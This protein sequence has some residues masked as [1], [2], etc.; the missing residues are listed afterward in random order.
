MSVA[1]PTSFFSPL[2]SA[3]FPVSSLRRFFRSLNF[4]QQWI[5]T[6]AFGMKNVSWNVQRYELNMKI[7]QELFFLM[8]LI[9]NW[10]R[11]VL[12]AAIRTQNFLIQFTLSM[13][14]STPKILKLFSP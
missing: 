11:K 4:L 8:S 12:I 10:N 1:L 7:R 13:K 9:L 14:Y 3:G 5:I 6:T 2:K